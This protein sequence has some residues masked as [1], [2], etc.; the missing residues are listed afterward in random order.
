MNSTFFMNASNMPSRTSSLSSAKE[1]WNFAQAHS[2]DP[3]LLFLANFALAFEAAALFF[4]VEIAFSHSFD[5]NQVESSV[6]VYP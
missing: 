5:Q 4:V 6:L 3:S 1:P 2:I